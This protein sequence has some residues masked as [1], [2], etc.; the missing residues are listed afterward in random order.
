MLNSGET[1]A[2]NLQGQI[3]YNGLYIG[4]EYTI[5]EIKAKGYYLTKPIK[6]T[7]TSDGHGNYTENINGGTVKQ[8]SISKTDEI[9]TVHIEIENE[10]IPTYNLKIQKLEK[11][12]TKPI[13]NVK[14]TLYKGEERLN[15]YTTDETGIIEIKG[16]YQYVAEKEVEQTYTLKEVV[17]PEGYA[18]VDDITFYASEQEG[19]LKLTINGGTIKEQ[20]TTE[21]TITMTIEDEPTFVLI[22]Q[23]GETKEVLPGVKFAIYDYETGEPATDVNGEIIG[24]EEMIK[25]EYYNV[26]TTNERG[27]ITA[28]LPQGLYKA[29]ELETFEQYELGVEEDRTSYFGIDESKEGVVKYGKLFEEGFSEIDGLQALT[30]TLTTDG[31]FIVGG[32]FSE[33]L[34][35]GNRVLTTSNISD[36]ERISEL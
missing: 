27:K 6:L 17:V 15:T 11:D 16:L 25:G 20:S 2:T 36:E 8:H 10:K 9:P 33:T 35:V 28:N 32:W 34:N 19:V 21:D 4:Q 26:V 7:I 14:F 31:S 5:E 24:K 22:K 30:C 12:T 29:V 3:N 23:D 18:K 1:F 13:E